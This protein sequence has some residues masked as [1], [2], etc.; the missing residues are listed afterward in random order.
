[1]KVRK[2]VSAT[3]SKIKAEALGTTTRSSLRNESFRTMGAFS[4]MVVV[5]RLTPSLI[6]S[7]GIR[8]AMR[9]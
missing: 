5:E 1:M 6:P 4:T 9:K 2:I 8:P 3:H 7:H